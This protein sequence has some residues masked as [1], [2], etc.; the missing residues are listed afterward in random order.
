MGLE[1]QKHRLCCDLQSRE[2]C[3]QGNWQCL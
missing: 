3:H 1:E 2:K